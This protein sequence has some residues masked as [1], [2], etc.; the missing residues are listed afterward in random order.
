[1]SENP[2]KKIIYIL[3]NLINSLSI[4]YRNIFLF[5]LFSVMSLKMFSQVSNYSFSQSAGTYTPITGGTNY[6]NFTNWRNTSYTGTLPITTNGFLDDNVSATLQPIGFTFTYNGVNYTQF[7]ICTNGFIS[8]GALPVSSWTPIST[9][10]SN[11]IISGLGGDLIGRGSLRA[12]RTNGSAAITITAGDI[13]QISVGDKVSG[14]G[15]AVGATVVS[16]TATTVTMSAPSTSTGTGFHFRFSNP[17]FGIRYQTV[18]TAPNRTLVIQWTG[19]QRWTTSG[20]FGELYD[21]QIR[22]NET[23]N[24]ID[25]VYNFRGP[26][27]T[28]ST[29][30][31]IGLR[32]NTNT[33]FNNR[34]STTSWS[35]TNVGTVN[36]SSITLTDLIKPTSG[37]TYTWTPPSCASPSGLTSSSVTTTSATI[38]WTAASPNPSNGYQYFYSTSSTPP[39]TLTSP[40]GTTTGTSVNLTGLTSNVFYYFWVRSDCGGLQSG[41]V[42]S[43][44]FYTGILACTN[45][46][47]Y[48]I[49]VARLDN[50]PVTISTCNYQDEYSTVSGIVVGNTY[51]FGYSR[52][53]WISI[54]FGT[55]NGTAVASGFS[56]V[57]WTATSSGTVYVHYNTNSSCGT[58]TLCGTSTV[59]CTSCPPPLP[60][61]TNLYQYITVNAPTDNTPLIIATDQWQDEFNQVD[62]VVDGNTYRSNYDLGGF[63]TVRFGTYDG[64]VVAS[65]N[66]PLDWTAVASGTYFIHYNTNSSCGNAQVNGVS[67]LTCTSCVIL[68]IELKLFNGFTDNKYNYLNWITETELNSNYFEIERSHNGFDYRSIGIVVA[69]M[70]SNNEIRYSF[71]DERPLPGLNYYRLRMVDLDETFE[72]SNVIAIQVKSKIDFSLFYPNPVNEDLNYSFEEDQE[73]EIKVEIFDILGRLLAFN[74]FTTLVG[75]NTI[76][77]SFSKFESGFYQVKVTHT[78]SGISKVETIIKK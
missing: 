6:D 64:S 71:I 29:T 17:N 33:D 47:D 51:Q 26:N 57:T 42:G 37:L 27:S 53:G 43:S 75:M 40:S 28:T 8:L 54:R 38:S 36:S 7:G 16:K 76:E 46:N 52:G 4:T 67:S 48:G 34:S 13:S 35:S 10:T 62:N 31:E 63:I 9:G 41:W 20:V 15:I 32:G 19:F 59:V 66:S 18:G 30:F 2:T 72:Y 61:C 5:I 24:T 1:M 45:T 25:V 78:K 55:P 77:I 56:P 60:G 74:N 3:M 44:S 22:L 39:T 49:A 14:A 21:F 11:N 69:S 58:A 12:N 65:G 68:P 50:V 73:D 23:T 70:N